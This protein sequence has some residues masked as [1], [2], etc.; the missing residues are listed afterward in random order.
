MLDSYQ[1]CILRNKLKFHVYTDAKSVGKWIEATFGI[2]C[3]PQKVVNL[4]NR[5][6]FTYQKSKEVPCEAEFRETM[7]NFFKDISL[8]K[9]ELK[10]LLILNFHL[11]NS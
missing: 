5:I 6:G 10:T 2:I 11:S 7:K 4:L 1:P 3:T 9:T 8:Y